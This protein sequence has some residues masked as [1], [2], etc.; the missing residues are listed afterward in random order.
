M[1]TDEPPGVIHMPAKNIYHDEV[2]QALKKDG[3]TITDDPLTL[4]VDE[5]DLFVDLAAERSA[6]GAERA[7]EKIAVEIQSFLNP[8]DVRNLQEALGQYMLYRVVLARQQPDRPLFLAV[9]QEVYDRILSEQLGQIV[10]IDLNLR[11]M[12]FD[13]DRCEVVQWIS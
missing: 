13:P 9:T 5:R 11:V 8:S 4:R 6:I 3:W 10:L 1:G 7:G 12:T 2:V